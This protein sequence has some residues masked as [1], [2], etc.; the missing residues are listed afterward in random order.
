MTH[1]PSSNRA[2]DGQQLSSFHSSRDLV[3]GVLLHFLHANRMMRET[4]SPHLLMIRTKAQ[5]RSPHSCIDNTHK[6]AQSVEHSLIMHT[7]MQTRSPHSHSRVVHAKI[8]TK[9]PCSQIIDTKIHTKSWR[10]HMIHIQIQ[11]GSH[12]LHTETLTGS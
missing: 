8:Q 2:N 4:W 11:T 5:T 10:S 6:D 7:K 1:L 12:M 9:S 3:Q